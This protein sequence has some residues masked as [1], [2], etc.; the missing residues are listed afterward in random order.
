[1]SKYRRAAKIDSNQVEIVKALRSIP[2]VTVAVNHDDILVGHMHKTKWYEIKNPNELKKDGT[3]K[4][5]TLKPSQVDLLKNWTG[6]YMVVST[7]DEILTD[8]GII[9]GTAIPSPL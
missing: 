6:H 4:A 3:P 2:G 7:L 8:L 9:R 5:G 1:M